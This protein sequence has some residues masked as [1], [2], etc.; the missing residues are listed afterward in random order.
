M[1]RLLAMPVPTLKSATHMKNTL[2]TMILA[3]CAALGGSACAATAPG[4][5]TSVPNATTTPPTQAVGLAALLMA[6]LQG[7]A[8]PTMGA[9]LIRHGQ[10]TERA[11]AGVRATKR[12]PQYLVGKDIG[13]I[14][15]AL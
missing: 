11:V 13:P 4:A 14:R 12:P 3:V 9:V 6:S 15:V 10:I 1:P 8:I 5:D 2:W 7:S